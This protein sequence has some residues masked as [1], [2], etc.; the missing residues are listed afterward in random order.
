MKK[1]LFIAALA[2]VTLACTSKGSGTPVNDNPALRTDYQSGWY[3]VITLNNEGTRSEG[4][5]FALFRGKLEIPYQFEAVF[6]GGQGFRFAAK[7]NLW[8][9][10]GYV[11]S[12]DVVRPIS[13]E[14]I[15]KEELG[16]GFYYGAT[17]KQGTPEHWL[18]AT[19]GE[20]SAAI[21]PEKLQEFLWQYDWK[22][23]SLTKAELLQVA[24]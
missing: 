6:A 16:K 18:M 12:E 8:D 5:T 24:P 9:S 10:A 13:K 2:V 11:P 23:F 22:P 7:V 14:S 4:K 19:R 20:V 17:W 15:T 3:T 1:S 21:D